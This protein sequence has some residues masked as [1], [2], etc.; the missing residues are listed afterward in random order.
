MKNSAKSVAQVVVEMETLVLGNVK[1][2]REKYT[3]NPWIAVEGTLE[4]KMFKT[5]DGKVHEFVNYAKHDSSGNLHLRLKEVGTGRIHTK[6][7]HNL[8]IIVE[9]KK[10]KKNGYQKH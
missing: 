10:A 1:F 7:G 2:E 3:V 6:Y 5:R 9:N 4:G 8:E